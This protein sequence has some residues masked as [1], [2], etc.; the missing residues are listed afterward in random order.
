MK[1]YFAAL[2]LSISSFAAVAQSGVY[3]YGQLV[4]SPGYPVE[5]TLDFESTPPVSSTVFADATGNISYQFVEAPS[6]V[7]DLFTLSFLDC[8]SSYYSQYYLLDSLDVIIEVAIYPWYCLDVILSG[9]T[10]PNA[11]NYNPQATMEDGSCI[12]P[13]QCSE[14]LVTVSANWNE[15]SEFLAE[16]FDYSGNYLGNLSFYTYDTLSQSI[17]LPNGCY[18]MEVFFSNGAG[19]L[20]VGVNGAIVHA[21]FLQSSPDVGGSTDINLPI[22]SNCN[23]LCNY[24]IT[25]QTSFNIC[26]RLFSIPGL[27]SGTEVYWDFGDG[28]ITYATDTVSHYYASSSTFQVCASFYTEFCDS[29]SICEQFSVLS[30]YD[31]NPI[32]GCTD[33]SAVNY[34]PS[35]NFDNGSCIYQEPCDFNFMEITIATEYW[36]EEISWTLSATSG[37]IIAGSSVNAYENYST[38]TVQVCVPDGCYQFLLEDSLGDGWNYAVFQ[39]SVNGIL[40]LTGTLN[41]GY[42]Q[43]YNIDLNGGNCYQ[44]SQ[45]N[46]LCVDAIPLVPGTVLIDNT[47]ATLNENIYGACWDFGQG[48]GEQSS[49]WYSFTTPSVPAFIHI[50]TY[51]DGTNTFTDTQFGLF[52]ECFGPMIYCGGNSGQGLFSALTFECGQLDTNTTYILMIDGWNGDFGT[53]FL[54]FEMST[55]CENA[56]YGC[57]DSIA[58]NY[59]PLA[60]I[61]DGSCNFSNCVENEVFLN[62]QATLPSYF[63]YELYQDGVLIQSAIVNTA[64][65]LN[66]AFCLPDGCYSIV[67]ESYQNWVQY[68]LSTI[69]DDILFGQIFPNTPEAEFDFSLGAALCGENNPCNLSLELSA[70][71]TSCAVYGNLYPWQDAVNLDVQWYFEN[72]SSGLANG[73]FWQVYEQPGTYEVCATFSGEG[74]ENITLCDTVT[75]SC[76][77][78]PLVWGC[79][80]PNA[81]NYNP[82]AGYNDGSCNYDSPGCTISFEVIPDSLGLDIFYIIPSGNIFAADSVLWNFGDGNYSTDLFPTHQYTADGPYNICLTVFFISDSSSCIITYCALLDG[83]DVG[84][85]GLLEGN[86]SISILEPAVLATAENTG[87]ENFHVWPN[88]THGDLNFR[89]ESRVIDRAIIRLVDLTGKTVLERNQPVS[90]QMRETLD[91]RALPSGVY[92]LVLQSDLGTAT[93]RVVISK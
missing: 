66:I 14:N 93:Q 87:F 34:N 59:N 57:T 15:P 9:C 88:P 27:V 70:H 85:P 61:D 58:G 91:V 68:E 36:A 92:V 35:A 7:W 49:V 24:Q 3:I 82:L 69:G 39:I 52:Q 19:N 8:D 60:T 4:N 43:I 46:D 56:I 84:G 89:F 22:N 41:N 76:D 73:W 25:N 31:S 38:Y 53:C 21:E 23:L 54:N 11:I 13:P 67:L 63:G 48:E 77:I 30:C 20:Q 33:S 83:S 1:A 2:I 18:V 40:D 74:C 17:C 37:D 80:D 45:T 64:D 5:I 26:T 79:T 71:D 86:F 47:G 42:A 50:E 32:F 10:D 44:N 12:Y 72:G 90:G 28:S 51:G 16:F 78:S 81:L 75:L 55:G 29:V 62:L 65:T 6:Q